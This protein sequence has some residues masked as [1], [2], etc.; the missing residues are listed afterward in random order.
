M[1]KKIVFFFV[2]WLMHG[3]SVSA[4]KAYLPANVENQLKEYFSTF[5]ANESEFKIQ[6]QMSSYDIDTKAKKVSVTV[7]DIFAAQEFS[8]DLVN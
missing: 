6:P 1:S 2:L 5:T 4:Q 8:P 7:S 3:V